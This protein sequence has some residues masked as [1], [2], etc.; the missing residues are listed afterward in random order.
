[1]N[2]MIK[3][4]LL[5]AGLLVGVALTGGA[6]YVT[7]QTSRFD[8]SLDKIYEVPLPAVAASRDPA[9]IERGKHVAESLGGC[10]SSHCH[11]ADLGGGEPIVIGPVGTFVG[12][13]IT[14]ASMGAV[15]SDG[16]LARLIRHGLKKDGRSL[17]FMPV[18]DFAWLP[19]SDIL[20]VVSYLRA[21]PPVDRPCGGSVVKTLGKV[22][23]RRD[24][25]V[26]DVAR[27]I[28][29]TKAEVVPAPGPTAEY[30]SFVSRSCKGCHGEHLGG[31]PIPGAPPS[32]PVPLNLTPDPT[33]LKDWAFEDFDKLMRT[34]ERKNGKALDPFMPIES[35]RHFDAVEM[36]ALWSYLRT[37]SPRPLG[38]R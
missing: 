2:Q 19:D 38:S 9:V 11:G 4:G 37:V 16:E 23:D 17:R 27:R 21:A 14:T 15:Y 3:R 33:G 30:G 13:N 25:F 24:A 20:A 35:W 34:G 8:A 31:G 5:G 26:L 32:I 28:D 12:P 29:H 7:L 36:R 1:M 6:G 22:L 18:Q 10:A